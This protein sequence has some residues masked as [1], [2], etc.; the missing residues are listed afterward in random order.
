MIKTVWVVT[1]KSGSPSSDVYIGGV[2][3]TEEKANEFVA[4]ANHGRVPAY[5][6][7]ERISLDE[8]SWIFR[9]VR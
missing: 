2:F 4:S 7:V 6:R 5:Y 8:T 3:T 1:Y 9:E